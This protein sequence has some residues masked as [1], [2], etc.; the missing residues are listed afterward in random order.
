VDKTNICKLSVIQL[1][2]HCDF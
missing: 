1:I 2:Y